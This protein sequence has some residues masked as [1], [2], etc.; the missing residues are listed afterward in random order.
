VQGWA[1]FGDLR[2]WH[3]GGDGF[4]DFAKQ[5]Q[6]G[7]F[8]LDGRSD[9]FDRFWEFA[10]ALGGAGFSWRSWKKG[11]RLVHFWAS[12]EMR[13]NELRIRFVGGVAAGF[14]WSC[15]II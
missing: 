9:G 15:P 1:F 2:R 5:S 7:G 10:F 8:G 3:A 4:V 6:S 14:K 12:G 11:T 13:K